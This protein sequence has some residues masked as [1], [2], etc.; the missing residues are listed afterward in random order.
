M[1]NCLARFTSSD[2]V[3]A[4]IKLSSGEIVEAKL[5][6]EADGNYMSWWEC[7]T[8]PQYGQVQYVEQ[9]IDETSYRPLYDNEWEFCDENKQKYLEE[10]PDAFE[11]IKVVEIVKLLDVPDW[12]VDEDSLE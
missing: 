5:Y 3:R 12:D 8:E 10:N 11:N 7:P 6:L 4:E 9:D 1:I 2:S